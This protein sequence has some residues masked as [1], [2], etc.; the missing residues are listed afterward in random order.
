MTLKRS[1]LSRLLSALACSTLLLSLPGLALGEDIDLY[2]GTPANGGQPNV[3]LVIDNA[4]AW[5]AKIGMPSGAKCPSWITVSNQ[6]KDSDLVSC[7]L[8]NA[9]TAIGTNP[10]LAGR[11]NMGLMT[12]P[13]IQNNNGGQFFYPA[14]TP[15]S[16]PGPLPL[17]NSTGIA[18]FQS[19]IQNQ[20]ATSSKSSNNNVDE[21]MQEAWAYFAGKKGLS[22]TN[23]TS[24]LQPCQKT[25][26]IYIANAVNNDAPRVPSQKSTPPS[27]TALQSAGATTA[28]LGTITIPPPYQNANQGNQYQPNYADEWT[29]FM[30]QTDLSNGT[31]VNKQNIVTYTIA[32]TDNSNSDYVQFVNSMASNGGGKSFVINVGDANALDQLIADLTQIFNEVQ[33]VNSVFASVSLPVSVNGQGSYL[34]Q[35]YVGMFR[36]DANGLPRWMG[37]LK[38]YQ[39]GFVDANKTSVQLVDAN[40]NPAISS[41]G[42]G[43]I[44]TTATSFW[45]VDTSAANDGPYLF[46]S[47]GMSSTP[48]PSWPTA[49]F[50]SATSSSGAAASASGVGGAYDAPDGEIVEKGGVGEQIR[51][52]YLVD[53]SKRT[54]YTCST[55]S[56]C[57]SSMELFTNSNTNLL[58]GTALG[59]STTT[60]TAANLIDWVRGKDN[61]GNETEPGP[62]APVTVRPS[63]HGD[64]LHSRPAVVNYGAAGVVVYYG[65]NDGMFHAINGNKPSTDPTAPQGINGV[66]PGG[67]LWSFVAPEFFGKF[68]RLYNNNPKLKLYGSTDPTATPK[69]YFFDGT[70]TVYQDLRDPANPRVYIYLSAR[71]GGNFIYAFDVTDPTKPPLF[72]WKV[73][74]ADIQELGQTWSQPKVAMVKGGHTKAGALDPVIIMGGGYDPA[75]DSDP[76]PSADT[77]GRAI[78]VLDAIDG[79]LVWMAAPSCPSGS[80]CKPVNVMTRSIPADITL[81]D[82]NADGYIERLYAADVGGNIWRVDLE[83]NGVTDPSS[84]TVTQIASLGGTGNAA[85]KFFYPPDVTPTSTFDAV[86]AAT[87]DREHPL[88]SS[89][90]TA[91]TAYNVVNR[92]YMLRDPNTGTTVANNWTPITEANL[93]DETGA[94]AGGP[95]APAPY[96]TTSTTSGFYITLN[97]PG[98]KAVNAPLTVAGYTYF[99]TNTPDPDLNSTDTT[100]C[101]PNLGIARGYAINFL[102]GVGLN[103]NGFVVFSGGGFPPSP[104][105]GLI[106]IGSG[107]SSV[108]TPVL[109][110]GGNQ[111]SSTGGD[112][113]S[114]LGAQKIAPPTLGKRKRTY[115]FID[116]VK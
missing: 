100:K 86:T 67:E 69:D 52:D 60:P 73:T 110:G 112:S 16:A 66:R 8:Y 47:S 95:G 87:G 22:G 4:A 113:T 14:A 2:T 91:G 7:G 107:N 55:V 33:A 84:W 26:V 75:E 85:R 104:V 64:V 83:P 61:A 41:A 54:V 71:R 63:I 40:G 53:Q 17:M 78:V 114:V 35:I 109:I 74:N 28:Q 23:Y 57:S 34:N 43:F 29:R 19:V 5:D 37:N 77:K 68:Q 76:A 51:I 93:T 89:S 59:S 81:L 38:Q 32:M 50:W 11:I 20:L 97:H 102:T 1:P 111:T 25:F 99:G 115:W 106:S 10:L 49:G 31:N 12:F 92:F 3:L 94:S 103:S 82:R 98:E 96:S 58:S 101:Y 36:P 65:S 18:G 21:A 13:L 15:P 24:P 44:T 105:F 116:G 27:Y 62:G 30:Y 42:T 9:V 45:T 79:S 80:T 108:I 88:Y 46:T 6:S 90:T 56:N 72:K 70:A 48:V 39:L